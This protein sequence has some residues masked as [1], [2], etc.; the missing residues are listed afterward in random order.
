MRLDQ[1]IVDRWRELANPMPVDGSG[2]VESCYGSE[3]RWQFSE[4]ICAR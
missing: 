3:G 4:G 1:I 2:H